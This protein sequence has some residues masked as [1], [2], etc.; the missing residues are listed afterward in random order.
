MDKDKRQRLEKSGWRIGT[1]EDFLELSPVEKEIVEIR[2]A[3]SQEKM[4]KTADLETLK[5]KK[6]VW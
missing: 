3:L 6:K 1:V 5:G 2:L 4:K